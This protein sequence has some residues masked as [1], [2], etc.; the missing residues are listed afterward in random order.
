VQSA[1]CCHQ[2]RVEWILG[3]LLACRLGLPKSGAALRD[4]IPGVIV[5]TFLAEFPMKAYLRRRRRF[6]DVVR[7]LVVGKEPGSWVVSQRA[8]LRSIRCGLDSESLLAAG[9]AGVL[10]LGSDARLQPRVCRSPPSWG[11]GHLRHLGREPRGADS[12]VHHRGGG[13]P[14]I[15][16]T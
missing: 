1:H 13:V 11:R 14:Q 5:S 2:R 6:I 10:R 9:A 15:S 3:T 8:Y 12:P 7:A 4:I 16:G